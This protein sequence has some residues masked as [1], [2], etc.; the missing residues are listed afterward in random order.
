MRDIVCPEKTD[1]EVVQLALMEPEYYACIMHRYEEKLLRFIMR[2]SGLAR[3]DAE[4]VLQGAFLKAYQN[5]NAFD[6]ALSF[7]AWI[8]R[9]ALNETISDFRRRKVRPQ[10]VPLEGSGLENILHE[11]DVGFDIDRRDLEASIRKAMDGL[12][13]G[14]RDV[15][16][17]RYFEDR[18]YKE[19]ADIL[20]KPEGTVAT[21]LN[22]AKKKLREELIR[23]KPHLYEKR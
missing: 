12:D 6:P 18:G 16:L 1:L 2:R 9:I 5:L 23:T 7:S 15:L 19:I 17:L 3:E 8:Y 21:L 11:I 20:E 22:R 13:E 14:Q 10:V 4:D